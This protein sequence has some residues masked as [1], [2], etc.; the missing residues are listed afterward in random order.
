MNRENLKKAIKKIVLQEITNNQFGIPTQTDKKDPIGEKE[1]TKAL[2]KDSHVNKVIGTGKTAGITE[3]QTVELSKNADDN[4]DV[5]S[6]T[7]ESERK[8]ARGVSLE[9]AME[10][11]KKHAADSEKTYVQKAYDKTSQGHGLKAEKKEEKSEADKMDDADEEKQVDIADD[12][13]VKADEKSDKEN[14]P[15]NKDVAP[16]MGGDLVD[17]IEKIIDKV[18]KDKTK[19]DAK[20]A[21]LK[22]DTDTESPNKLTTKLKDTPALKEKK[23]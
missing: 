4:Y 14:A 20:S 11:V 8:I 1:L 15:I 21:Y 2:G 9:A 3:K 10:L 17:K 13:T 12:T 16:A 5:V 23:S 19:A 7:N 22:H 6:V 18:L